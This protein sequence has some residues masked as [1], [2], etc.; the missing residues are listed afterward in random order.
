MFQQKEDIDE[1]K[2]SIKDKSIKPA[3]YQNSSK[4]N[5]HVRLRI[6]KSKLP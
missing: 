6:P 4:Q 5:Q 3:P 2:D 1:V